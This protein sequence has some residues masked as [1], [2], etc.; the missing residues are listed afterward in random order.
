MKIKDA[1]VLLEH[2]IALPY[3]KCIVVFSSSLADDEYGDCVFSEKR[4]SIRI[5]INKQA[6]PIAQ[7]DALIHEWAHAMLAG[8]PHF[9][10]HDSLWGVCYARCYRA[11]YGD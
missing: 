4:K 11:V 6:P 3:D 1:V 10:E 7:L 9:A 2:Q 5:R 8:T